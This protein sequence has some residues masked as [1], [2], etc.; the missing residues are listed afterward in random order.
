LKYEP[1][2]KC[3]ACGGRFPKEKLLRVARFDGTF[4]VDETHKKPGRGAY[5]C[6]NPECTQKAVRMKQLNRV[7]KQ[8][9]PPEI[10]AELEALAQKKRENERTE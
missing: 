10:Y 3:A 8:A 7:F 1:L 4:S 5:V 6:L 9:V 2:R